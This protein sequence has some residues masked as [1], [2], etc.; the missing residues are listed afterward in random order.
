MDQKVFGIDF[1]TTNTVVFSVLGNDLENEFIDGKKIIKSSFRYINENGLE[2]FYFGDLFGN[3]VI[4]SIKR[5]IGN[6]DIK[7][8]GR[9]VESIL[10]DIFSYIFSEIKMKYV[11]DEYPAVITVPAYFSNKERSIMMRAYEKAGFKV[12]KILNEPTA[13]IFAHDIK[14]SGIYG[15]YDFG[16]GTFDFSIIQYKDGVFNVI[17]TSGDL[18][19]GGDD[20]DNEIAK[21]ISR[22]FCIPFDQLTQNDNKLVIQ[23]FKEQFGGNRDLELSIHGFTKSICIKVSDMYA[24]IKSF[25]VKTF[26]IMEKL[27]SEKNITYIDKLVLVGGSSKFNCLK[28]LL[29][30]R[31]NIGEILSKK[32]DTIVAE[33][34]AKYADYI[35]NLKNNPL[36]D[37]TPL[38]LGIEIF[39][40]FVDAI[41]PRN[42]HVP[43]E[44]TEKYTTNFKGQKYIKIHILQGERE[45]ADCC[46]SIGEIIIEN[47]VGKDSYPEIFVTFKI[48]T[49]GI[50][51]VTVRVGDNIKR[52][53]FNPNEDLDKNKVKLILENDFLKGVNDIKIRLL[54]ET[55]DRFEKLVEYINLVK[56]EYKQLFV[57]DYFDNVANEIDRAR[58][59]YNNYEYLSEAVSRITDTA[60]HIA[61][62]VM[63]NN[64]SKF[65]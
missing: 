9:N 51:T 19:L 39:G 57:D 22:E 20:I 27:L 63:K 15:V 60:N 2:N 62:T 35:I 7:F 50:L 30:E 47:N 6:E 45:F 13:A 11:Q 55:Q 42:S 18:H 58:L 59:N 10:V 53:D 17:G 8:F 43:I 48:D 1:G 26:D 33:G 44:R 14:D 36:I 34:A 54:K 32:P 65:L 49:D 61:K 41:I 46:T 16:G 3:D 24:I 64:L 5:Y 37:V 38:T 4:N 31:F 52:L 21:Y 29:H 12:I 40:G 23:K 56:E 28:G 25:L